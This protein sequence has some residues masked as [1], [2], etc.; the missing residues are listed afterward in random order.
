VD[1]E[2]GKEYGEDMIW[3][4]PSLPNL[5]FSPDSKCLA[6]WAGRGGKWLV[7]VDGVEGKEYDGIG[8]PPLFSP[9]SSRVAYWA[10]R[11]NKT[12]VVVDRVEGKKYDNFQKSLPRGSG[13][14]FD[15]AK[16]LH[17]LTLRN[18]E[19]FRVEVEIVEE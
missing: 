7:V 8:G 10:W 12:F 13:L 5:R 15:S 2:E 14:V 3:I 9:S 6:Y 11:G 18:N 16:S 17:G 4:D 19:F 1:G